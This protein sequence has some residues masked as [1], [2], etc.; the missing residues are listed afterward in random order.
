MMRLDSVQALRAIA[1]L[2]VFACH[3]FAIEAGHAGRA[4]PLT[5]W[6]DNGAY[7]VDLFFVISGFIMVWVAGALPR[8]T[9]SARDFM[10]ARVTRIYPLWWLFAGA[11]A[12]FLLYFK[13]VPWDPE[14]LDPKGLDGAV[15]LIKSLFLWPQP[16]HPVLGVG[17]TLVHEMYFYVGFALLLLCVPVRW[18]LQA[19]LGW[20]AIVLIGA[21]AGLGSAFGRNLVELVFSP[22]TLEF[23]MGSLVGYIIKAG[24]KTYARTSIIL[25]CLGLLIGFI[26]VDNAS[27]GV[28]LTPFALEDPVYGLM[29]WGRVFIFG[30]PA[31]LVL[32]GLVAL[33]V[34]GKLSRYMSQSL[35]RIGDWS[36]ALYL[37]HT[38]T[39]SAVG[40]I[41]YG[42]IEPQTL[43]ATL[44]Y[45]VTVIAATFIVA[46]LAYHYFERPLIRYFRRWRSKPAAYAAETANAP[47]E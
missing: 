44:I 37:C 4:E 5:Q 7:G 21:M 45:F 18:R 19:I 27:G 14:R 1:A 34:Q 10:F 31:A 23:V 25:G 9:A 38:L 43:I 15:H 22:L 35:V 42:I 29:M 8:G 46:A 33:D 11:M 36:Y 20:G 12:L 3:L 32:Y 6:F 28:L 2:V 16:A 30:L 47:A 24:W 39:I 26:F 17:W 41:V 13:G 40:R